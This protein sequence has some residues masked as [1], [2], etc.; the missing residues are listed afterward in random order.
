MVVAAAHSLVWQSFLA[1]NF[2]LRVSQ[3]LLL[4]VFFHH[5]SGRF[6]FNELDRMFVDINAVVA[7]R[8][9]KIPPIRAILHRKSLF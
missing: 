6:V 1:L 3:R 2:F 9:D 5:V 7:K 8:H 4:S